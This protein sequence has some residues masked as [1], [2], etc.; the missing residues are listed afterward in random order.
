MLI[1]LD[2]CGVFI[3]ILSLKSFFVHLT[4]MANPN[5][6]AELNDQGPEKE[7]E[8]SIRPSS[9][10]EFSGQQELIENLSIFIRAANQRGEAL[11]H[12]LFHGPPGFGQ[13]YLVAN[14]C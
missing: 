13:N 5:L 8:N 7:F 14:C 4:P 1:F 9:M 6:Q 2:A 11:D 10:H 12:V 3:F